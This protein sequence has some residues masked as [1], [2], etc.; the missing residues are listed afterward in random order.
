VNVPRAPAYMD[1]VLKS[2]ASRFATG[3]RSGTFQ[4]L[5]DRATERAG[6]D[7]RLGDTAN[8]QARA[9]AE[10]ALALALGIPDAHLALGDYN[11]STLGDWLRVAEQ[12][13]LG[14]QKAP[15]DADLLVGTAL[16]QQS[17]GHW[18]EGLAS[19]REA[20]AIDPRS[21]LTARRLARTL[22]LLRH[23]AESLTRR[24][25]ASKFPT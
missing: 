17:A 16:V 13:A 23:Y 15:R 12:Y 21:A 6:C 10:R 25:R 22:L 7:G 5:T 4:S 11:Q 9:A 2:G 3:V 1:G 8:E 18:E 19:L 20:Q 14:R 24:A